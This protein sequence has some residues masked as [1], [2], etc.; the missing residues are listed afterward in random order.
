MAPAALLVLGMSPEKPPCHLV[1]A[2]AFETCDSH[3]GP[4]VVW[5]HLCRRKPFHESGE[6]RTGMPPLPIDPLPVAKAS[7][8]RVHVS[9]SA[10][11]KACISIKH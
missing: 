9:C 4:A 2:P 6:A 1:S 5:V 7:L 8:H 11:S 10:V 3:Q